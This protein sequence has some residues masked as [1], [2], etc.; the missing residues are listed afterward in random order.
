MVLAVVAS[1]P[2]AGLAPH[3][4]AF[5]PPGG[6]AIHSRSPVPV[7]VSVSAGHG[8]PIHYWRTLARGQSQGATLITG[9]S[10]GYCFAQVRGDGYAPTRA[11]GRLVVHQTLYGVRLPDGSALPMEMTFAGP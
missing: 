5:T 4:L 2:S 1:L 7:T 10:Y 8:R 11:C 6:V 9:T 3:L